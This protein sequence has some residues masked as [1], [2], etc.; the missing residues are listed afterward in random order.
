[1]LLAGRSLYETIKVIS[2]QIQ[3][4][5][6]EISL[7]VYKGIQF[8]NAAF[9]PGDS[10][11]SGGYHPPIILNNQV[12]DCIYMKQLKEAYAILEYS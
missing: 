4:V 1:L 3:S 12:T 6:Y 5:L 8:N 11:F 7:N 9:I 10:G 2:T